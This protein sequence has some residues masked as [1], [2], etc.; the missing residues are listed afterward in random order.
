MGGTCPL[1][2]HARS[3]RSLLMKSL[4][5]PHIEALIPYAPGKPIEEVERETGVL[6]PVK[7]ASNEN[8]LGPSP[9]AIEAIREMLPKLHL[10][11]DGGGFYLKSTLSERLG[12]KADELILGNGS[13]ELIEL[14]VRTF[15]NPGDNVV[16]SAATFI[17]YRLATQACD[18]EMRESPLTEAYGYDLEAM[19]E[20]VDERTRVI[21]IAN[22]N[23]PT[24][25]L[26]GAD[27]L[28][29]F[30]ER[31]DAK[32]GDNPPIL[33]LDE[34]YLEYVDATDAPDAM[35][36]YRRRARVVL[37]RTFSKAYGLAGFRCGYAVASPDLVNFMNRV[38]APFNVNSLALAGAQAAL[39]DTEFLHEAVSLNRTEKARLIGAFEGRGLAVV[40]SQTNFLLVDFG[41]PAVQV[42]QELMA[43]G[44]I[45]RP[46]AGYGL[47]THQRITV[48]TAEEN[49][50]LLV[51]I[52]A[53]LGRD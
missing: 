52:D 48:G 30:I 34:A 47:L 33:V 12:V 16:T 11:P 20:L 32:C 50:K 45:V 8:P 44:I 24:G 51:A 23:N 53:L 10:Y 7:L 13:N 2:A 14:L 9:R 39:G 31:V 26:V 17:A 46:M 4:V 6:N 1:R 27:A 25:T 35:A 36:L 37:M 49:R 41:R 18:R 40:P 5:G 28:E 15:L 29:D 19:A 42:F 22:P 43:L 3:V 21:F 38:R